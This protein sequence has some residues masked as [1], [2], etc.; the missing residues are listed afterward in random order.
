MLQSKIRRLFALLSIVWLVF[1]ITF[2]FVTVNSQRSGIEADLDRESAILHRLLSQ[3]ADQ[4]DAHLTSLSALATSGEKVP[5]DLFLQVAAA[6]RRFYP[7][8]AA[9]YL[10]SLKS[11]TQSIATAGTGA[12]PSSVERL[13]R[14]AAARSA[15][16]LTVISSPTAPD[17]YLVVKRSP[18][19]DQARYGLALEINAKALSVTD[20][21]F[22]NKKS[23]SIS[24][25]LPDKTILTGPVAKPVS[26]GSRFTAPIT[27]TKALGSKSQ[28][29]IL[30]TRVNPVFVDIVPLGWIASGLTFIGILLIGLGLIY[31]LLSRTRSAELRARLGEHEAQIAQA[32]RINA[33][34]EMASGMAH[35]LTQPLTAILSQSQ[36]GIRLLAR[37]GAPTDAIKDVLNVNIAQSKRAAAILSRLREWS[38][39]GRATPSKQHLNRCLENVT[40]L[41]DQEIRRLQ[42][43]R[44]IK[45]DAADPVIM[46]DSVEIEQVIFNLLRNAMDVLKSEEISDRRISVGTRLNGSNAI[47][48]ITDNGQGIAPDMLERLY[49]PFQSS[50]EDGMGLGLALCERI[51]ERMNGRLEIANSMNGGVSA[52]AVF[53]L[54]NEMR[55]SA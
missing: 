8:I 31:Q 43:D 29:L 46:G 26:S 32:S 33:L 48:E 47:V 34:G 37:D 52:R 16:D 15:G 12:D 45:L 23:A 17:R 54:A 36:A 27:F 25:T 5:V 39:G 18:N 42:I 2:I 38:K 53:P 9:I 10:V 21:L 50:K 7:R 24:L 20:A 19:S 3:R 1:G 49:E 6:I 51:M 4:H 41:L 22:W 14:K 13:V 30:S 28:P 40:L 55:A 11:D 44:T 35:E